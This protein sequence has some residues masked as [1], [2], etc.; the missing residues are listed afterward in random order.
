MRSLL[1]ALALMTAACGGGGGDSKE[2]STCTVDE[3]CKGSQQC[4]LAVDGVNRCFD[5]D[6]NSCTVGRVPVGRASPL[7]NPTATPKD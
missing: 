3:D 4:V 1:L 2:C 6:E 7:P 5:D